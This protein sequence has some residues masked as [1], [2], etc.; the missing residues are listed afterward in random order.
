MV[1]DLTKGESDLR[2]QSEQEKV[3]KMEDALK[4]AANPYSDYS[5]AFDVSNI[6]RSLMAMEKCSPH[7][8]EE[9]ELE[10]LKSLYEAWSFMMMSI[11]DSI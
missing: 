7:E 11:R 3:K 1:N 8:K 6:M 9:D 5:V 4:E 10:R 2:Y